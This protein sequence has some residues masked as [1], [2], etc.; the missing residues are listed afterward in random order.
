MNFDSY[1]NPLRTVWAVRKWF[2]LPKM[3]FWFYKLF[4]EMEDKPFLYINSRDI[5]WK[6]KFDTPRH[7][8]NPYIKIFL[9]RK[10]VIE[11]QFTYGDAL[12]DDT[13]YEQIIWTL[14][15]CGND[16]KKAYRTWPWYNPD[17]KY[18]SWDKSMMTK[19]GLKKIDDVEWD[20]SLLEGA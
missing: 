14:Y 10:F 12:L 20:V 17:T 16:M 19:K 5:S 6:P 7:E 1:E 18:T 8:H 2:K 3:K 9:F 11:I 15:Y 4:K 13:T